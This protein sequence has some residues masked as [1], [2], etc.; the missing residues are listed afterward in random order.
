MDETN[1]RDRIAG[2]SSVEAAMRFSKICSS[3]YETTSSG[4]FVLK[5]FLNLME[6]T[7]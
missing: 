4:D 2:T 5:T 6:V 1:R 7:I 3:Y